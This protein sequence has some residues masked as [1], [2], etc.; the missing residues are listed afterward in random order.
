MAEVKPSI[1]DQLNKLFEELDEESLQELDSN[2]INESY[3]KLYKYGQIIDGADKYLSFSFTNLT[4][5]YQSKLLLTSIIGYQF[6][7]NDEWDV[8]EDVHVFSVYDYCRGKQD[9]K[10][11]IDEHY[12]KFKDISPK[13]KKDIE[14]TKNKMKDRI[15]VRKFLENLYQ[16]DPDRHVRSAYRPQPRDK[17]RVIIN[18][19]A[20][21]LAISH[22]Q[23]KD[24]EFRET[25]LD[26]ER[27]QNLMNMA[28]KTP[29]SDKDEP[30]NVNFFNDLLNPE[31]NVT[32]KISTEFE[33]F[34]KKLYNV[35]QNLKQRYTNI[36]QVNVEYLN[37]SVH[38]MDDTFVKI[39]EKFC[40][41]PE[42]LIE[43]ENEIK[44]SYE[45]RLRILR[46]EN[47]KARSVL[48]DIIGS[49]HMDYGIKDSKFLV[50]TYNMIPPAD[51]FHRFN[52]YKDA[53]YDKLIDAV[54]N[55]YCDMPELDMAIIPH[56]WHDTDE[57]ARE[58]IK[59][60]RNQFIAEGIVAV[61]GEWNFF[62]PY[63]KVR[64]T[65]VFLNDN[66]SVLE[67]ILA[68]NKRDNLLGTDILANTIKKKKQNNLREEGPEAEGFKEWRKQ[69]STLKNMGAIEID[70][71][72]DDCPFDAIEVPVYRVNAKEGTIDKTK[73]YSKAEA[74]T[75][76]EKKNQ[77]QQPSSG[78][79][80]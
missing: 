3:Q 79:V 65:T 57:N 6:R 73:F 61:S 52:Y 19:P 4:G 72:E 74:P 63:G 7:S 58:Y 70:P 48:D 12:A 50:N 36:D 10:D 13:L 23:H 24:A 30:Y 43:I 39:Q 15:V 75:F 68:Q 32:E 18:T 45:G 26:H 5:A 54:K 59:R 22:L 66:T 47:E 69:N 35:A 80:Q 33:D 17:K 37:S 8:P 31:I 51:I 11:I 53:N 64:D 16:F 46:K 67:E 76:M 49:L 77:E 27:N 71:Y 14:E 55:L 38:I 56:N 78:A 25:M 2:C 42:V 34:D 62:A 1:K 20:A 44:E 29:T 60:H 28:V 21:K 41:A 40:L 9:G